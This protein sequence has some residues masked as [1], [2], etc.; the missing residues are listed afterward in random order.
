MRVGDRL[1]A[2][3]G[4]QDAAP[5]QLLRERP[6]HPRGVLGGAPQ[7]VI[8]E[9]EVVRVVPQQPGALIWFIVLPPLDQGTVVPPLTE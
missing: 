1:V 4:S 6:G 3:G 2:C 5:D 9:R 7:C 8:G